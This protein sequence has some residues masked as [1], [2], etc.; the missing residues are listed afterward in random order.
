M[1]N[2]VFFKCPPSIHVWI[3]LRVPTN[4][5]SFSIQLI[6]VNIDSLF[7]RNSEYV[8]MITLHR[9]FGIYEKAE[10]IISL[11]DWRDLLQTHWDF[12][13][14]ETKLWL[15]SQLYRHK[16][17]WLKNTRSSEEILTSPKDLRNCV[18]Q[19]DTGG[20][21]ARRERNHSST[22]FNWFRAT[23]LVIRVYIEFV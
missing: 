20:I 23:G 17:H 15:D 14:T 6:F 13:E 12:A 8:E 10:M 21:V 3:F 9:S 5:N 19:M 11:V 4:P 2:Y 22:F 16:I 7:W 1:I 18:F